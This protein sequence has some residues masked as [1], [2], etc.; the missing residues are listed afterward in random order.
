M[1]KK[2]N[3]NTK[4]TLIID[5]IFFG[6]IIIIIS[7]WFLDIFNLFPEKICNMSLACF[8]LNKTLIYILYGFVLSI[9]I[10]INQRYYGK[11]Q[12]DEYKKEFELLKAVD[13][14]TRKSKDLAL[15]WFSND[16]EA[17]LF[18]FP[19]SFIPAFWNDYGK[20]F[21]EDFSDKIRNLTDSS[22]QQIILLGPSSDDQSQINHIL[23]MIK[24]QT[25]PY[26]VFKN[27]PWTR[28]INSETSIEDISNQIKT[29]YTYLI[30]LFESEVNG[31]NFIKLI[32]KDNKDFWDNKPNFSFVLR[33][34]KNKEFEMLIID[35]HNVINDLDETFRN[36]IIGN[37]I[38]KDNVD[39]L[40][41]VPTNY[42]IRNN[43]ALRLLLTS[44]FQTSLNDEEEIAS[45]FLN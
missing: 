45:L 33:K 3:K 7:S 42:I 25:K 37:S 39:V 38:D 27:E 6:L 19:N 15:D 14:D 20:F 24:Q 16:T 40:F 43:N 22:K 21:K 17:I 44:I 11:K 30:N 1:S 28:F 32:K 36:S 2:D 10:F 9:I 8:K 29:Q 13:K 18:Y 31:K 5:L 4:K 12:L 41:D 26:D 34:L 35:T 23:E